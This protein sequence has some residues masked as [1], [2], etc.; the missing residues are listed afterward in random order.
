MYENAA[1]N[2]EDEMQNKNIIIIL[3]L[4]LKSRIVEKRINM[5]TKDM[6]HT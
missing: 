6:K 4:Q 5:E 2:P 1:T 3:K